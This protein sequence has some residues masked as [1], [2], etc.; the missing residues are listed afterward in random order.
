MV[1]FISYYK[2]YFDHVTFQLQFT[3]YDLK[4]KLNHVHNNNYNNWC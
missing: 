2:L 1:V 4:F 3:F